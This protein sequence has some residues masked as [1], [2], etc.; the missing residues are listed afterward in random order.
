M[1]DTNNHCVRVIDLPTRTVTTLSLHGLASPETN[2]PWPDQSIEV[3]QLT[4]QSLPAASLTALH[5]DLHFPRGW[6][7]NE[8]APATLT[9]TVTGDGLRV[10]TTSA[11]TDLAAAV[12]APVSTAADSPRWITRMAPR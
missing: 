1:A 10:P 11:E 6:K 3:L 4:E 7:V 9:M 5:L 12:P 2:P 8:Q